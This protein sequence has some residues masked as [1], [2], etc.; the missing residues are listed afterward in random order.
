VNIILKTG[1][2][3]ELKT[4]TI[5]VA[6]D[7]TER[8]VADNGAPIRG[9]DVILG[10]VV[11]FRDITDR[12]K[13]EQEL[14]RAQKLESLNVL[15]G[16]IAHDFTNILTAIVNYTTLAKMYSTQ[17]TV[18]EKL[19]KIENAS[20]Q[21]KELMQ[22]LLT[23]SK[24]GEP[25]KK[26]VSAAEMIRDAATFALRGSNV[27]CQFHIS[28]G[29]W[30]VDVDEGQISQVINN[31]I[32]NADHSMPEG[33]IIQIRAENVG[34]EE[35]VLP[36]KKGNYVKI[37]VEDEGIGI[38]EK[39]LHDIFDPY[40]T[41]KQKGSGL[42]LSASYSIIKNHDGH[43]TV[44]SEL[45]A[46]T[47]VDIYLPASEYEIEKEKAVLTG[48]GRVLLMDDEEL[49]R[50]AA[51]EVLQHL[52]YTVVTAGDGD[53]AV[54]I[55]TEALAKGEPFD[56]VILDLTIPGGMGGKKTLSRLKE[57]DPHVKA[58][59]CTGY[60]DDPVAVGFKDYG[61]CGAVTKPY[62]VEQL[63]TVLHTVLCEE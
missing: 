4:N 62:T 20:F 11:V 37:S 18:K 35:S 31:I 15:A 8:I 21:A 9:E 63:S 36:L 55:Y 22:Y 7:G 12:Q 25:S 28:E 59:I 42:G 34:V 19:T 33:G 23:F 58:V 49:I 29:L 16:G 53:K 10:T 1:T 50:E 13:M 43:I 45:G 27:K 24:K 39:H 61:F 26:T 32:I 41:T 57:I 5:L 30:P 48:E 54:E 51:G 52:G 14:L 46:G 56:V 2:R 38:P 47:T 60:A 6:K 3:V 40:F 17:D 44:E